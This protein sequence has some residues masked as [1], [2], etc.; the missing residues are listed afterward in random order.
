MLPEMEISVGLRGRLVGVSSAALAVEEELGFLRRL[1]R[2]SVLRHMV[3]GVVCGWIGGLE[4][5]FATL[6]RG[7][8]GE[9]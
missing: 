7:S 6:F 9:K 4:E 3:W 5:D 8:G 2:V 1:R